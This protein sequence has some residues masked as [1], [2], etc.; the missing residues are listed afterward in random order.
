VNH[1]AHLQQPSAGLGGT[2]HL[3]EGSSN[4]IPDTPVLGGYPQQRQEQSFQLKQINEAN[5]LRN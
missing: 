1:F 5:L 3:Q 4:K 2:D